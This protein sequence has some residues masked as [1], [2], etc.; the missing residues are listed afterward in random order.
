MSRIPYPD[1]VALPETMQRMIAGTPLGVVRM[2][3][4][5]SPALFEAQGALGYAIARPDVL[6]PAVREVVILVVAFLS[7]SEYELHQHRPLARAA[8]LPDSA[9]EAIGEGD[10]A[11][12]G[13]RLEAIATFA[14]ATVRD[15]SPS[16][17]V[18]ARVR[19]FVSDRV[20]VN[21]VLTVGCYM[22][23]AR[24]IAVTG[25]ELDENR[26]ESLPTGLLE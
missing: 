10:Y 12:L 11:R 20:L 22:T 19:R 13:P 1:L 25:L 8:G 21:V 23:I 14:A 17:E 15:L 5:A 6:E 16:D 18:L 7:G 9:I 2:G 26:L 4:H 3:A 24:L